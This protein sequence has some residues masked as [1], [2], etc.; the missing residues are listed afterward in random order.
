MQAARV[1]ATVLE[2]TSAKDW[3]V[4]QQLLVG[5]NVAILTVDDHTSATRACRDSKVC[6]APRYYRR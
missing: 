4:R 2:T 5:R 3:K 6:P 1:G